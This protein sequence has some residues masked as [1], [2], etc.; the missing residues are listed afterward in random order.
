ML[1]R[2][3]SGAGAVIIRLF[4]ILFLAGSVAYMVRRLRPSPFGLTLGLF[5]L[6]LP[7]DGRAPLSLYPMLNA[8]TGFLIALFLLR[9]GGARVRSRRAAAFQTLVL[10]YLA[11]S[12]IGLIV[13]MASGGGTDEVLISFKRWLDPALFGL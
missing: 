1:P 11:L 12:T 10:L 3:R 4:A 5:V 7:F 2:P 13:S 6:Y 9:P 8:V